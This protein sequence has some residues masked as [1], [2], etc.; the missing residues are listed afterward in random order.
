MSP[1]DL[2][3]TV[4]QIVQAWHDR[5]LDAL[6]PLYAPNVLCHRPPYPDCKDLVQLKRAYSDFTTAFPDC[7]FAID[8]LIVE[9]DTAVAW[10][11]YRGTPGS[12]VHASR[13]PASTCPARDSSAF[14]SSKASSSKRGTIGTSWASGSS[15][16]TSFSHLTRKRPSS[17]IIPLTVRQTRDATELPS[18]HRPGRLGS[19]HHLP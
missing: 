3:T 14:V 1:Q 15:S 4:R 5:D 18:P 2:K 17:G 12:W 11:T 19:V 8:K 9:G 6:D 13:L 7:H 16:T 10:I